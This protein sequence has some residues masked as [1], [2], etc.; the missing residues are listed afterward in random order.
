[1]D[2]VDDCNSNVG[3]SV[4]VKL[5]KPMDFKPNLEEENY[6]DSEVVVEE[7]NNV[8]GNTV[9]TQEG[10]LTKGE[11]KELLKSTDSDKGEAVAN[12]RSL[13]EDSEEDLIIP[14]ICHGSHGYIHGEKIWH[15]EK[16][17]ISIA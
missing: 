3:R 2:S 15:V 8:G 13:S 4:N 12:S 9:H 7:E 14:D 10:V 11:R 5:L 1:M 17:Q 16:F 6:F